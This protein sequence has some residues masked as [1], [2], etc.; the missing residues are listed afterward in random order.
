MRD[1]GLDFLQPGGRSAFT[2]PKPHRKLG[3]GAPSRCTAGLRAR[4]PPAG[5]ELTGQATRHLR[6]RGTF[7]KDKKLGYR[8][9]IP[10]KAET[11]EQRFLIFKTSLINIL[12]E[13]RNT[14]SNQKQEQGCIQKSHTEDW[15]SRCTCRNKKS[16]CS[17]YILE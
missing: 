2:M 9:Q 13:L 12:N 1:A 6:S 3:K 14:A 15:V 16:Q 11:L 8:F 7:C 10:S 17:R 5:S 4:R